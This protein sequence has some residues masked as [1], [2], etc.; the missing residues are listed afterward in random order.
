MFGLLPM[1]MIDRALSRIIFWCKVHTFLS[2]NKANVGKGRSAQIKYSIQHQNK[3]KSSDSM[4]SW[5]EFRHGLH[6]FG[7]VNYKWQALM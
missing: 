5:H 1:P 6:I 3:Q 2:R 4:E 7:L